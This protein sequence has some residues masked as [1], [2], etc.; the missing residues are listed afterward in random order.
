MQNKLILIFFSMLF[1]TC[2]SFKL[3]TSSNVNSQPEVNPNTNDENSAY[4]GK[5]EFFLDIPSLG[6]Y[7]Y[8]LGANLTLVNRKSKTKARINWFLP[9]KQFY[10]FFARNLQIENGFISFMSVYTKDVSETFIK[11]SFNGENSIEGTATVVRS[12]NND[13]GSVYKL[14][15]M[16]VE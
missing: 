13:V 7:Q 6:Q 2:S 16:K 4:Y 12:N 5:Y 3:V 15:G 14:K 1:M 8:D 9:Q 11:F 10:G